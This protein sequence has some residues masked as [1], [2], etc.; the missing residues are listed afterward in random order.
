MIDPSIALQARAPQFDNPVNALAQMLQAQGLQQQN[1]LGGVQLQQA[2]QSMSDD[3]ALRQYFKTAPDLSTPEGQKGLFGAAPLKATGIMKSVTETQ[4]AQVDLQKAKF[5]QALAVHNQHLQ[6]LANVQT[7]E[8]AQ[9][10]IQSGVANGALTAQGAQNN[11]P[12]TDPAAF[13]AWKQKLQLSG[14]D[15]VKQIELTAP[16]IEMKDTGGALVPINI[17]SMAPGGVGP[18]AGVAPLAKSVS[19]DARLSSDTSIK[20]TGMSN[21]TSIATTG[22]NNRQS[23]ANVATQQQ[24]DNVRAGLGPNGTETGGGLSPAAIENAAAR[25]NVDGTLPPLSVGAS[26]AA[27]KRAILN[28]AA[29]LNIGIAPT[30][31]RVNQLDAKSASTALSQL[32]KA[33]TMSAAFEDTANQ[34]AQ[35]ALGLSNKLDR[36]GVPILNAGLQAWRTGTGSPEATQFAAANETFVNEYAK[37]MSGGMGNGPVSDAARSKAHDLLATAMTQDQYSGNVKLL[38]TEMRNRMNGFDNQATELRKRLGSSG[39]AAA[40]ASASAAPAPSSNVIHFG[41]LK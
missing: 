2:Q 8:Q 9:A 17:N 10:W 40:P 39:P 18:V 16:K 1:Q 23:A 6:Q 41:D 29:D 12:P 11:P 21:A 22:M 20:T 34:N 38:Q 36:T 7:P 19:P 31:Q 5:D 28:R 32:T 3:N 13:Q 30:D 37:I 14:A 33:R 15:A 25:Y 26:G 35:L 24:G 4:K 27:T